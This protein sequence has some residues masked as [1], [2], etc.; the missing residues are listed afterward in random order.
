[1]F[2]VAHTNSKR[3][4]KFHTSGVADKTGFDCWN[5]DAG[6]VANAHDEFGKTS[7]ERT[8]YRQSSNGYQRNVE[9]RLGGVADG[10]SSG[11]DGN[12]EFPPEPDIPRT[13]TGMKNRVN[14]LK[15]L[16]N[17]V[18]PAQVYPILTAISELEGRKKR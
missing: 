7:V 9:P 15:C 17:A 1:V 14:R 13:V 11:L 18:V 12:I 8:R 16:G 5:G 3:C 2:V 4:E 10:I 6:Y